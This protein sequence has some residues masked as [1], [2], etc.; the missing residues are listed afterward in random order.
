MNG[1]F[2]KYQINGNK[3]KRVLSQNTQILT[4]Q[5]AHNSTFQF[6]TQKHTPPGRLCIQYACYVESLFPLMPPWLAAD[7]APRAKSQDMN[8]FISNSTPPPDTYNQHF[9]SSLMAS[10]EDAF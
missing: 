6:N 9:S 8:V 4:I 1:S 7:D 2:M 3:I 5:C 10:H